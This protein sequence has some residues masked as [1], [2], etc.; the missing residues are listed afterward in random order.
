MTD[1]E[2]AQLEYELTT[3]RADNER[4]RAA[5]REIADLQVICA[6]DMARAALAQ[7][8]TDE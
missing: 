5:L 1:Q 4:L 6:S 3:L 7:E 2:A 8:K